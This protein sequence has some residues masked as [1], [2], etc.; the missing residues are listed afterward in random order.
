MHCSCYMSV[1]LHR[2]NT[3]TIQHH[4][5]H[6]KTSSSSSSSN[7]SSSGFTGLFR[8]FLQWLFFDRRMWG[9]KLPSN[10][11]LF[12]SFYYFSVFIFAAV[13]FLFQADVSA[14][15]PL[16]TRSRPFGVRP[17]V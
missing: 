8:A 11:L 12:L 16:P 4:R 3:G 13:F 6:N 15:L 9:V 17:P 1:L 10:F 7:S 2:N 14:R 5:L